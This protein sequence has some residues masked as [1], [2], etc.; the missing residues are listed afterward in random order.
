M[1]RVGGPAK[2]WWGF[3]WGEEGKVALTQVEKGGGESTFTG[4]RGGE[5]GRKEGEERRSLSLSLCL[6][7]TFAAAAETEAEA[8]KGATGC[9]SCSSSSSSFDRGERSG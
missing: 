4:M 9:W 5:R 2:A 6:Y 1:G 7:P 3:S 8:E